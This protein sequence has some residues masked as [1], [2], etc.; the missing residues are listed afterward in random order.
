[1]KSLKSLWHSPAGKV[2]I[3]FTGLIILLFT[4]TVF[5]LM[6]YFMG[7]D[8]PIVIYNAWDKENRFDDFEFVEI[9]I[10]DL[11]FVSLDVFDAQLRAEYEA[12]SRAFSDTLW[13]RQFYAVLVVE[14]GRTRLQRIVEDEPASGLYL[15]IDYLF[16]SV[17]P[18]RTN[19]SFEETGEY[20]PVYT[21]INVYY[22]NL[23]QV[24]G[25]QV[26][27]L[28]DRLKEE[29]ITITLRLYRGRYVFVN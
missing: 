24:L 2:S 13:N 17:D 28:R 5:P 20:I 7:E 4:L 6:T 14:N 25:N 23:T 16:L 18:E 26:P 12:D 9:G 11:T 19:P 1:M 3:S 15:K 21:G 29:D 8:V 27:N 10:R 22:P